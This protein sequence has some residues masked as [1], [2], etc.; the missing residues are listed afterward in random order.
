MIRWK[1]ELQ[2]LFS[3]PEIFPAEK[4]VQEALA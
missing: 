1:E 3:P 4:I 2:L